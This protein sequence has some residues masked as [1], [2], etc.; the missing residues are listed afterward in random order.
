MHRSGS[1]PWSPWSHRCCSRGRRNSSPR[2]SNLGLWS[3][4]GRMR[5]CRRNPGRLRGDC[6]MSHTYR[7]GST[8]CQ[9]SKRGTESHRAWRRAQSGGSQDHW[10]FPQVK[11]ILTR[12]LER[13]PTAAKASL[14]AACSPRVKPWTFADAI[15]ASR[16]AKNDGVDGSRCM[17]L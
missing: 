4:Q 13:I 5:R 1:K 17:E 10:G 12:P 7:P 9:S 8:L 11:T 2:G 15:S 14:M 16:A 6:P 3:I